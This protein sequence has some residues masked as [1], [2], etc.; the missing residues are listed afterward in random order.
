MPNIGP[1]VFI[2]YT[3]INFYSSCILT[4]IHLFIT[5]GMIDRLSWFIGVR[6]CNFMFLNHIQFVSNCLYC[7]L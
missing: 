7:N 4:V 3:I 5:V 6:L 1:V 2:V